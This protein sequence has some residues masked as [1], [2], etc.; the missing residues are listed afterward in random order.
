ME[1]RGSLL[2]TVCAI[3]IMLE[4]KLHNVSIELINS[5]LNIST[6]IIMYNIQGGPKMSPFF[7]HL[8]I[9]R[10]KS[11]LFG[12]HMPGSISVYHWRRWLRCMV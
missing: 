4:K 12:G 1:L 7:I 3:C 8:I 2:A 11:E 6:C 9:L 5:E 10:N